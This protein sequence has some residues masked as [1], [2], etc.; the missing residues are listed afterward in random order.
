[1][2]V[3][4]HNTLITIIE[5]LNLYV[6]ANWIFIDLLFRLSIGTEFCIL[7]RKWWGSFLRECVLCR[8]YVIIKNFTLMCCQTAYIYIMIIYSNRQHNPIYSV[9]LSV[10]TVIITIMLISRTSH[11]SVNNIQADNTAYEEFDLCWLD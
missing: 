4:Y 3:C 11:L 10:Y 6:N 8:S 2:Y 1:M 5:W 9:L 7:R